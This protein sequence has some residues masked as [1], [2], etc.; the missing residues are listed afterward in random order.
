MEELYTQILDRLTAFI[1]RTA[2][3][4]AEVERLKDEISR[5]N[6]ELENMGMNYAAIVAEKNG[7]IVTLQEKDDTICWQYETRQ[8]L[9]AELKAF[10]E[11]QNDTGGD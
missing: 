9:E 5:L 10:K 11:K 6:A 1:T 2:K 7:L 8:K 4:E 3:A